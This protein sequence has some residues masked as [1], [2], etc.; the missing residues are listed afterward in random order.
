MIYY[1]KADYVCHCIKHTAIIS[2][3]LP[4]EELNTLLYTL[5]CYESLI[6]SF[7]TYAKGI[8]VQIRYKSILFLFFIK[9]PQLLNNNI[10]LKCLKLS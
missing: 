10:L 6:I 8:Q 4:P 1:V 7:K 9:L 2:I 5:Y 3:R